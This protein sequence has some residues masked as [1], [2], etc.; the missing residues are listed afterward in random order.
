[1]FAL[2]MARIGLINE[3]AL[4]IG[5]QDEVF[6]V[7]FEEESFSGGLFQPPLRRRSVLNSQP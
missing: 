2:R 7:A 6:Q 3:F 4:F 5:G 1:M